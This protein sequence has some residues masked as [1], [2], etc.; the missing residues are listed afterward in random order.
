MDVITSSLAI[1]SVVL[2]HEDYDRILKNIKKLLKPQG[3]LYFFG[4]L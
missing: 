2:N 1:D 4:I 3:Y